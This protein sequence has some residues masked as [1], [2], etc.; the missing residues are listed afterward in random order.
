MGVADPY[1]LIE[2][3]SEDVEQQLGQGFGDRLGH[4]TPRIA[5]GVVAGLI[6][7]CPIEWREDHA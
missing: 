3:M 4:L 1:Q 5:G 6:G 7:E 2:T